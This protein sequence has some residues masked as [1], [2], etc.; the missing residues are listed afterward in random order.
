MGGKLLNGKRVNREEFLELEEQVVKFLQSNLLTDKVLKLS[1]LSDK[2]SFGDIDLV[3]SNTLTESCMSFLERSEILYKKNGDTLSFLWENVQVDLIFVKPELLNF[4]VKYFS[5]GDK[6]N[7]LGRLIKYHYGIT[8]SSLG[9][10]YKFNF[11]NGVYVYKQFLENNKTLDYDT[12]VFKLLGIL[13]KNSYT[14][15]ELFEWVYSSPLF[16]KDI[17]SLDKLNSEQRKRDKDRT[18]YQRWLSW[19]DTKENK[20]LMYDKEFI[21]N[22][23]DKIYPELKEYEKKHLKLKEDQFFAHLAFSGRKISYY[24]YEYNK[25]EDKALGDF[26][27]YLKNNYYQEVLNVGYS[28][29]T[30]KQYQKLINKIYHEYL[31]INNFCLE[32]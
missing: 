18:F 24:L 32:S 26:I 15:E 2:T 31:R 21:N 13:P 8:F 11:D 17:Y 30:I 25:L 4:S 12:V 1:H 16:V 10:Y 7:L 5:H 27:V 23:R 19:L 28:V 22:L 29:N 14:E 20:E 9:P 3:V 6:S